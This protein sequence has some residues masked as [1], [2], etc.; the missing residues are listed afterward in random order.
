MYMKYRILSDIYNSQ[1]P[2]SF[3]VLPNIYKGWICFFQ[4]DLAENIA[5]L[6]HFLGRVEDRHHFAKCAFLTFAREWNG[7]DTFRM[8][9]FMM[10][11]IF[12]WLGFLKIVL[13]W[14]VIFFLVSIRLR[15]GC[16]LFTL[17]P[18]KSITPLSAVSWSIVQMWWSFR[19][20]FR[21]WQRLWILG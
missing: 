7:I 18:F 3:P 1:V 21:L 5:A 20:H 12:H 4:E 8:D 16:V 6:I 14:K 10:V 9:K 11:S 13:S 2:F 19:N 15:L 17:L